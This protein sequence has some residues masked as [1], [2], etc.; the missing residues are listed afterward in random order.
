MA[1][2]RD[3]A[4][5]HNRERKI[6]IK[7]LPE[8]IKQQAGCSEPATVGAAAGSTTLFSLFSREVCTDHRRHKHH[9]RDVRLRC[10]GRLDLHVTANGS[11]RS[12]SIQVLRVVRQQI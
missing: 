9:E 2:P 11:P 4:C 3:K 10:A 1:E 5:H 12:P 7:S 6:M 8:M